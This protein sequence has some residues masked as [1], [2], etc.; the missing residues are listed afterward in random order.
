MTDGQTQQFLSDVPDNISLLSY[1]HYDDT[2]GEGPIITNL[3]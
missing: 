3:G 2:P 1:S